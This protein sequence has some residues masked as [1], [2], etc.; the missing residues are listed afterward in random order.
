MK[1][2]CEPFSGSLVNFIT[3]E[4]DSFK[5]LEKEVARNHI[6]PN[7][8]RKEGAPEF[9]IPIFLYDIK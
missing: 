7:Q 2:I 6:A 9:Q 4:M 1:L 3:G 5:K 8:G